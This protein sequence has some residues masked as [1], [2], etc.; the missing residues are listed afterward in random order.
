MEFQIKNIKK[1]SGFKAVAQKH[2]RALVLKLLNIRKLK[3][4]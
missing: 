3:I 2:I 1:E 4:S